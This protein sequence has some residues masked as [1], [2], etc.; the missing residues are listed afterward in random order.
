MCLIRKRGDQGKFLERKMEFYKMCRVNEFG[1]I[2]GYFQGDHRYPDFDYVDKAAWSRDKSMEQ[3]LFEVRKRRD[4]HGQLIHGYRNCLFRNSDYNGGIMFAPGHESYIN[5]NTGHRVS[6]QTP[7]GEM[8]LDRGVIVASFRAPKDTF[9]LEDAKREYVI[10][11]DRAA[12]TGI[13]VP[14]FDYNKLR[15]DGLKYMKWLN[16]FIEKNKLAY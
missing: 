16:A 12:I 13:M 8:R 6:T 1:H 9:I 4:I 10:G 3:Y 7:V 14:D 11:V 15:G 5:I 2:V